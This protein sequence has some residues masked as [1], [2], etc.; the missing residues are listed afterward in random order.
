MKS[1]ILALN[2]TVQSSTGVTPF[3]AMCGG[4]A[5]LPEDWVYPTPDEREQ[6]ET[7][8]RRSQGMRQ[9]QDQAVGKNTQLNTSRKEVYFGI[10]ISKL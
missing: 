5:I 1:A 3:N 6:T 4:K 7:L 9:K 10:L 8:W 2:T